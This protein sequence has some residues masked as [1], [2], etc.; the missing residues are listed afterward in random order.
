MTE[1][2]RPVVGYEGIYE[3]SDLG[4]VR[5]LPRRLVPNMRLMTLMEAGGG[6]L[7]VCLSRGDG[8]WVL[9]Y[10]HALVAEAWH[11][12]RP[13]ARHEVCHNDGDPKNN[14]ASNLRWGTRSDNMWDRVRHGVHHL[15]ART[16]CKYGH[17]FTPENTRIA[18]QGQRKCRICQ[19]A[20][21]R[22]ADERRRQARA[23]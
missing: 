12:P 2:W 19:R 15:A 22:A 9:R 23:A 20:T 17:E 11:G 6:H 16:H 5:S 21:K 10:V 3:V 4:R 13:T 18:S 14:V 7:R 1:E 8:T